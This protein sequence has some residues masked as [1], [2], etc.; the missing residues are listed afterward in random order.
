[1]PLILPLYRGERPRCRR[2]VS[3]VAAFV[4]PVWQ[5]TLFSRRRVVLNENGTGG[6][7]P[8]WGE[9]LLQSIVRAS[10]RIGVPVFSRI[11]A[12]PRDSRLF[13]SSNEGGSLA[14]PAG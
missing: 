7:S 5:R 11:M 9:N 1:M 2:M 10:R 14:R 3:W 6:S 13:E 8:A 12:N 4:W